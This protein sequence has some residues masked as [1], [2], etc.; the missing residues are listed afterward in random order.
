MSVLILTKIIFLLRWGVGLT[1]LAAAWLL[2]EDEEGKITNW[3]KTES[4]CCDPRQRT[5]QDHDL[6]TVTCIDYIGSIGEGFW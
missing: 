2:K 1:V 3:L 4:D 5:I 6:P